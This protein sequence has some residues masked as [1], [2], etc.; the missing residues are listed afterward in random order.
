MEKF[1]PYQKLDK[2]LC[3]FKDLQPHAINY[4]LGLLQSKRVSYSLEQ[5]KLAIRKLINDGYLTDM[6]AGNYKITFEGDVFI[7][8]EKQRTLDEEYLAKISRTETD[9][10]IYKNR[11]LYATWCAGIAASLLLLWQVFVYFYPVHKDYPYWIW[12][13]MPKKSF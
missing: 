4:L 7:G 10:R 1:T 11:L 12:E 8:Y 3:E 6:G 5:I 13:T 2:L 9:Q